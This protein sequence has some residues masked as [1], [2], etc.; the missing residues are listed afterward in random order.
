MNNPTRMVTTALL[1]AIATGTFAATAS[2]NPAMATS[3][4]SETTSTA[5][6]IAGPDTLSTE[7]LPGIRYASDLRDQSV[8]IQSGLGTLTMVGGQFQLRDGTGAVVAGVPEFAVAPGVEQAA[9]EPITPAASQPTSGAPIESVTEPQF[10]YTQDEFNSAL[11]VAATQFGLATGVG[12]LAGG[13]IGAVGGCI[14]GGTIGFALVPAFFLA[15]GP[16]GCLVGAGLGATIGPWIGAGIVGIP[17]GI[18]GA[19]QMFN[20]LN[21]PKQA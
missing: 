11:G 4:A 14:V 7:I 20:T 15:S 8:T 12:G 5:G 3:P 2:A 9:Q 16:A 10:I 19:A 17:V 21:A 1:A 18:A 13:L 6:Q